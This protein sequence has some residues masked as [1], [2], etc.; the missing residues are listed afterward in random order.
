MI[1]T[2]FLNVERSDNY[3]SSDKIMVLYMKS[4]TFSC[5]S[6]QIHFGN[7]IMRTD[8]NGFGS[9]GDLA[10]PTSYRS[11]KLEFLLQCQCYFKCAHLLKKI[12]ININ[13]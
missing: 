13:F 10:Q 5:T 11:T 7:G 4:D 12:G 2:L 3:F 9:I 6:I 1:I 8:L